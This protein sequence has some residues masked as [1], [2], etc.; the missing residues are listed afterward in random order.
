MILAVYP[1]LNDIM[2]MNAGMT[3]FIGVKNHGGG[4]SKTVDVDYIHAGI[5]KPATRIRRI[6]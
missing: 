1:N 2:G 3:P 5:I 6:S 4:A